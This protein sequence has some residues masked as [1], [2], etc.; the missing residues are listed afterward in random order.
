MHANGGVL[1]VGADGLLGS[2]VASRLEAEGCPVIRTSRRGA[3]G[4]IPLD[5][6]ALAEAWSPPA[7]IAAA[8]IC[9][10]V[11][12]TEECR[13]RPNEC[14]RVNVEATC[15]LGRRLADARRRSA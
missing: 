1:V 15:E 13:A 2:A 14:R 6:A 7:G 5:L 9:A 4:T 10:A 8:V 12:A 11:T 3:P